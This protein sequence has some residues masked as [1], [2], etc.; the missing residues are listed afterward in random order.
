MN[1]LTYRWQESVLLVVIAAIGAGC[2]TTVEPATLVLRNGKI[3][4]EDSRHKD[5]QALAVRGDT[6]VAIGTNQEVASYVGDATRV[7]DLA[8]KLAVPGFIEGHG[9]FTG[10]GD[11]RMQL[12]LMNV[13]NF[14][15]IVTLV[16]GAV[17]AAQPGQL[18]RGRGW[19]QAKWDKVPTP[20][21]EGVPLHQVLDR[22]STRLNSS[23]IQKSRMPSSA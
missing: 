9:H 8:G 10:V 13:K 3:L 19:H 22:K 18:I 11:A 7:I 2:S 16:A 4:T 20:N 1:R 5:A 17:K 12:N 21:V 15:E 6:L 23:H 14:D